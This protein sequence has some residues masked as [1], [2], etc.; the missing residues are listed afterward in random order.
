MFICRKVY[1]R[2][3]FDFPVKE[4]ADSNSS[5]GGFVTQTSNGWRG[6]TCQEFFSELIKH[7]HISVRDHLRFKRRTRSAELDLGQLVLDGELRRDRVSISTARRTETH[8]RSWKDRHWKIVTLTVLL[9][10]GHCSGSR[11]RVFRSSWRRHAIPPAS[12][13]T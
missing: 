6:G 9:W 11:L 3:S 1:F 2:R 4:Y 12:D 7:S 5:S 8:R 13:R 10:S